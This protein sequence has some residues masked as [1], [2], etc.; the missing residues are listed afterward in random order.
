MKI[1]TCGACGHTVYFDNVQCVRCGHR[2]GFAP[3]RLALLA[4]DPAGDPSSKGRWRPAGEAGAQDYRLCANYAEH[5][6]CNWL[7]P[8]DAAGKLCLACRL[9]RTI[10]DL[11]VGRNRTLW[12]ALQTEKNRLVYGLLRLGLP[13][14]SRHDTPVG[15]AFDFLADPKPSFREPSAVVTG[16]AQGVITLD[17][18][19]AD[20][21]ERERLRQQMAE[22][23]R[24]I[25]GH[26]RHEAGHYYWDRLVRDSRWLEPYR[27]RFGDE[28]ED[29]QTALKRHYAEGPP[30]DWP[31]RF[32]S[33]YASSHPWEDWAESWAHY[34]HIVDT[35][36]TAWEFGLRL[37]PRVDAPGTST[38]VSFDPMAAVDFRDL[39]DHWL[40]LTSA[41]NSLNHSM[42]QG[43]AYPFVLAPPAI[44]K[45]ELVHDIVRDS[46]DQ[47]AAT[48]DRTV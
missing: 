19:E 24:T 45:L 22:P 34:L 48:S 42:G 46:A 18:A 17:I 29:Y 1:F 12:R 3:D 11:S 27:T 21:A 44:D 5:A 35:L 2:L 20:D 13:V 37:A 8:A 43:D 14:Q 38:D 15:V 40:P 25:L 26:F 4:L 41:L 30:P 47:V 31:S 16:H 36:E 32:V 33:A 39:I 6:A 23:Y 10:P 28:R 9:N 7:V